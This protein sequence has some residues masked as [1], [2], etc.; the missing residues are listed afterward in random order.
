LHR[1]EAREKDR[2]AIRFL[3]YGWNA[4]PESRF[5]ELPGIWD[6][7]LRPSDGPIPVCLVPLP[8]RC[9]ALVTRSLNDD[10]STLVVLRGFLVNGVLLPITR[11]VPLP[12]SSSKY[13]TADDPG[14]TSDQ[15]HV[16]WSLIPIP[17]IASLLSDFPLWY[18]SYALESLLALP[19]LLW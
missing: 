10:V 14:L 19:L 6:C 5:T 16:D 13:H 1:R 17:C 3:F 9:C 12:P 11:R 2:L 18:F 7:Q 4:N 8:D 15:G